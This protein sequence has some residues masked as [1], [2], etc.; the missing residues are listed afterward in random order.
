[1][2]TEAHKETGMVVTCN[3]CDAELYRD[4]AGEWRALED[5]ALPSCHHEPASPA[6]AQPAVD[7]DICSLCGL[8][9]VIACSDC[10]GFNHSHRAA[11]PVVSASPSEL[12]KSHDALVEA[13]T[14][15]A[16]RQLTDDTFCWCY[17]APVA[18]Q[19]HYGWCIKARTAVATAAKLKEGKA[20]TG[21]GTAAKSLVM[22]VY[23]KAHSWRSWMDMFWYVNQSTEDG[24]DVIGTG[25]NENDAWADAAAKLK[26]G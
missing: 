18:E 19:K 16:S 15:T 21:D 14:G 20:T 13:L 26:E 24:N 7:P 5:S 10:D 23:P 11:P 22:E 2:T 17:D 6:P 3:F 12:Q 4:F 25:L 1:M 8:P 9:W